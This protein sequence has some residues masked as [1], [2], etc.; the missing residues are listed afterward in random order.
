MA[1]RSNLV[2]DEDQRIREHEAVKG[3]VRRQV[4]SEIADRVSTT[5]EDRAREA[6]AE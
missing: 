5:G 3:D 2:V 4:H 1:V 6:A